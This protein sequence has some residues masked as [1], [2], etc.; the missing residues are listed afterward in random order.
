[1]NNYDNQVEAG[2]EVLTKV[3]QKAWDSPT[4]KGELIRNP[5]QTL[6]SFTGVSFLPTRRIVVE[7]QSDASVIYLNIPA[8]PDLSH[9]ELSEEDLEQ[10]AG[11]ITPIPVAYVVGAAACTAVLFVGSAICGYVANRQ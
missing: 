4:F 3:F 7:D 6:Q 1:M 5:V 9:I 11:G 2:Q 8:Q 10:I